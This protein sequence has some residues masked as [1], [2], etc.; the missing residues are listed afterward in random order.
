MFPKKFTDLFFFNRWFNVVRIHRNIA[1][2]NVVRVSVTDFFN[3]F[4]IFLS[5]KC[6][7]NGIFVLFVFIHI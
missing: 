1:L 5:M 2:Y 6:T 3:D 4:K 7:F